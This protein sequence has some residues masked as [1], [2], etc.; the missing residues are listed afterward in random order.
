MRVISRALSMILIL[1]LTCCSA[2]ADDDTPIKAR[3]F[4]DS[5]GDWDNLVKLNLNSVGFGTGYVDIITNDAGLD[6]VTAMGFAYEIIY[7][8][9]VAF[10]QSHLPKQ[11]M[12]G[13]R[14]LSEIYA[15]LDTLISRYPDIMSEK[16]NIGQSY[17][18][19]DMWA[20]KI[21]DNPTVDE[22]EPGVLYTAGIHACEVMGPEVLLYFMGYLGENYSVAPGVSALVDNRELWFVVMVNPDGYN[23]L[24]ILEPNGGAYWRKNRRDNGDGSYGVDL[25]RNFGYMWGYDNYGSSPIPSDWDYRGTGPFS[26]PETRNLRDFT[27][28]RNFTLAV[29]NHTYGEAFLWPWGYTGGYTPDHDIFCMLGDSVG[30]MTGYSL[31]G[32]IA[33][34]AHLSNGCPAD[35]HYG[36][37]TIKNKIFDISPEIGPGEYGYWPP[38]SLIDSL[39]E[40]M[41]EANLFLARA[42]GNIY[43]LRPP[44]PPSVIVPDTAEST[45]SVAWA[46]H[47]TLNPAVEFE[48]LEQSGLRTVCDS[49][50]TFDLWYNNSFLLSS[51]RVF[52][53]PTSF[54]SGAQASSTTYIQSINHYPVQP[55]DTLRLYTFYDIET[56]R[57][58]AYV[59]VSTNGRT[60]APVPGSITTDTDPHG[61][62]RGHG[63]T[64]S[65]NGS[66]VAAWFDLSGFIGENV[67]VRLSYTTNQFVLREGFYVD[68]IYP[69][70][71]FN[72]VLVF[73]PTPDTSIAF[74]NKPGGNDY[75]YRAR[76]RDAENQWSEYSFPITVHVKRRYV[77]GDADSNENVNVSDA[78]YII[79]YV[80]K[81]GHAPDPLDAG[82]SNCDSSV[83]VSDAVH[84]INYIFKGGPEPCCP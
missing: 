57:D 51:A 15:H 74:T 23:H 58:Y 30:S 61:L 45:Y 82:D 12:G 54:H 39:S 27:L 46:H 3:I 67:L 40:L 47:D 25:N 84:L 20:V 21:S 2:L 52:S 34:T 44:I 77:C 62:N 28:S 50:S 1:L 29:Y 83:N 43:A 72:S 8:D 17:E 32:T 13:Y 80:F 55:G 37:Q 11:S 78:V 75:H 64:G 31:L 65:S 76:A 73:G 10:H 71:L 19:R 66:W 7:P 16:I 79:T 63:I 14:T 59:E 60:F 68:D 48:L 36:E 22:D 24:E 6:R 33:E 53:S 41:V 5:S 18:G 70:A 9:L 49:A 35:W 38:P 69:V 26:E 42:A 81:G 56:D 4:I